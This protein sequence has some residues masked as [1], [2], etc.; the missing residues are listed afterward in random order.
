M[1]ARRPPASRLL[2]LALAATV[3]ALA[4]AVAA[5]S[6]Q[7]PPRGHDTA[8][9]PTVQSMI[10]GSGGAILWPAR[11]VAAAAS[12][13]R[14]DGRRCAVAAGT[15]LAVLI[16]V[17]RAGGPGF[18]LRDYG[19]CGAAPADSA[20]LF[21][22]SLA[23]EANSGENGWEYKVDSVS[24]STGAA[25]PSG[26]LGNGRLLQAGQRVL[27]F[28]CDASGGGC[29]RTLEAAPSAAS[30][31]PGAS[32]SA[33]ITGYENE[34]RGEPVA[35]ATVTLGHDV[36]STSANGRASLVAPTTPGRYTL[37]ATRRGLVPS[38]PHTVVVQ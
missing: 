24:G 25:D 2:A 4:A 28:W 35:G 10:V 30:V 1:S 11:A 14:V 15:P 17:R 19:H 20:E 36:A 6:V 8:A 31:A 16:A 22:D 5:A 18:S 38:F 34:G 33:T 3:L 23:G 26:P 37:S 7:A 9:S 13:V 21:V 32:L 27:W 29:Q 12:S